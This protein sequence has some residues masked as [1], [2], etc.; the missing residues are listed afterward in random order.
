MQ[1]TFSVFHVEVLPY[2]IA[3]YADIYASNYSNTTIVFICIYLI[4]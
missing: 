1:L 4:Y 2:F 3:L